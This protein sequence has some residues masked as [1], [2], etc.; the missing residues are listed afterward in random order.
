MPIDQMNMQTIHQTLLEQ[1]ALWGPRLGI[2]IAVLFLFWLLAWLAH[3]AVGKLCARLAVH[4]QLASFLARITR[5]TLMLFG[6]VT[7]LGTAG[8][9]V[10]AIVAGLGLTGFALGFALK[11]SI[12]NLLAGILIFL[13]RPFEI[14]DRIK[15][16]GFE[17]VVQSIDLRY[18]ELEHEGNRILIPNSKLF[19][20]P[21]TVIR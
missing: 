4:A 17:G 5:L 19:T 14:Q 12:S 11:D 16:A 15:I 18:T 21:I 2:A 1:A 3:R 13:Y 9:D 7:A 10:S 20:D 6:I 8:V